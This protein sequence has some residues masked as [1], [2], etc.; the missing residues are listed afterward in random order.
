MTIKITSRKAKN[1]YG[2]WEVVTVSNGDNRFTV[3]WKFVF[4]NN[5]LEYVVIDKYLYILYIPSLKSNPRKSAIKQVESIIPI[6][7]YQDDYELL[8]LNDPGDLRVAPLT[9]LKSLGILDTTMW[10]I[11][12]SRSIVRKRR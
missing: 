7:N 6:I 4:K 10:R 12:M 9:L 2:D 1:T 3:P 8:R 5:G 11:S